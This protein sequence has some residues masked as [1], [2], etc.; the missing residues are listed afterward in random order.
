MILYHYTSQF[1][2]PL[3]EQAGLLKLTDNILD[4]QKMTEPRVCWFLDRPK[5]EVPGDHGLGHSA[6]DKTA[7]E[8]VV[9]VPDNWVRKWKPWAIAQG[10]DAGWLDVMEQI[11]G[12]PEASDHWFVTFRPVRADRWVSINLRTD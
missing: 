5:I 9:D 8:I 1:H 10:I 11:G 12:G 4:A 2:L 3:I 7:V 6:V